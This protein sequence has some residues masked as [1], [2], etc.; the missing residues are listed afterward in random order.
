MN[1]LNIHNDLIIR[2]YKAEDY[3]SVARLWE[4]TDLGNP[5][6]GDTDE[7]IKRTIESGGRLLIM[8]LISSKQVIGTSWLTNDGRRIMLHHFGILPQ[9][10][11]KGLSKIL[12]RESLRFVK[13]KG[14][15]V[16]L[17]VHSSNRK[18]I[19]L[20]E[21]FGFKPLNDYN[22]YIIRDISNLLL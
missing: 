10:Q 13:E 21:R 15:Q 16:K 7:T 5:L 3:L 20:Y 22:V 8:E 17:E 18:A 12:M 11:G 4:M 19:N 14:L 2:D 1:D 6:R 9:Y